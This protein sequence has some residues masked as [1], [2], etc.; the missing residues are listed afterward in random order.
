MF[1]WKNFQNLYML[2]TMKLFSLSYDE[3]VFKNKS[4][5]VARQAGSGNS[6]DLH[7]HIQNKKNQI[8]N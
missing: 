7:N 8:F 2:S 6:Y 4:G 5:L 3:D 1:S